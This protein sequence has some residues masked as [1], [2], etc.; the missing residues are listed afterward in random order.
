M[1][2]DLQLHVHSVIFAC[3]RTSFAVMLV[4]ASFIEVFFDLFVSFLTST[5]VMLPKLVRK[6]CASATPC[7]CSVLDATARFSSSFSCSNRKFCISCYSDSSSV[8]VLEYT[9]DNYSYQS[10]MYAGKQWCDSVPPA[11]GH[12][13]SVITLVFSWQPLR[14]WDI[15]CQ[16]Q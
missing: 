4:L 7:C 2:E 11:A 13:K 15:P 1:Y 14:H 5:G 12:S 9:L 16:G 8:W 3:T 10:S 6:S